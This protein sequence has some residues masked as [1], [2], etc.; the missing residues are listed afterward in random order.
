[1]E[2]DEEDVV[3]QQHESREFVCDATLSK[4]VVSKVADVLDLRV[5]HDE[6]PHR[7]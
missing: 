2:A 5:L 1:V 7:H 3:G 4:G 6:F